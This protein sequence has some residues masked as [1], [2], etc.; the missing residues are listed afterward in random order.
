MREVENKIFNKYIHDIRNMKKLD[1]EM[2]NNI[3]TMS[4]EE[5]MKIII[6]YDEI[7]ET[8]KKHLKLEDE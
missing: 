4:N 7:I 5:K 8:L 3:R 6:L 2:I 1:R